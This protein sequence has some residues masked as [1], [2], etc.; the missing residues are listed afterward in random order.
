MQVGKAVVAFAQTR[1]QTIDV[2]LA[3]SQQRCTERVLLP[4]CAAGIW[5][6]LDPRRSLGLTP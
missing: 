3:S 5:M 6:A 4:V 1:S 2:C